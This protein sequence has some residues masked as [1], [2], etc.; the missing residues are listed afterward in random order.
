[1]KKKGSQRRQAVFRNLQEFDDFFFPQWSDSRGWSRRRIP[2]PVKAG[3]NMA[4]EIL[5]PDE[6]E[7]DQTVGQP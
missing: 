7:Q 3:E 5:V 4:W 1:M 6:D 2:D